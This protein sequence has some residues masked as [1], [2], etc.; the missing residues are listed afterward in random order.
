VNKKAPKQAYR[1]AASALT[2]LTEEQLFRP[3]SGKQS[4]T[5]SSAQQS[6][7]K[8]MRSAERSIRLGP[9]SLKDPVVQELRALSLPVT[10]ENYLEYWTRS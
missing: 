2:P 3:G 9:E 4:K 5:T 8:R 6:R 10:R 7:S 1:D